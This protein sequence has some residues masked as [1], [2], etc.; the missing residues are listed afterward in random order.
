MFNLC[1]YHWRYCLA[2][3]QFTV[4]VLLL[5]LLIVIL[6]VVS[7]H[8][9]QTVM[10]S[11]G[12]SVIWMAVLLALFISLPA[13]FLED[14]QD[15]SLLQW[16]LQPTPLPLVFAIRMAVFWSVFIL[17]MVIL[18]PFVAYAFH[19]T[20]PVIGIFTLSLFLGS[21]ALYGI[22]AIIAALL[23]TSQH[24]MALL[25]V[26]LLPFFIPVMILGNSVVDLAQHGQ[27]VTGLI[28]LILAYTLFILTVSPFL[29]AS[30]VRLVVRY[31]Y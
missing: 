14:Y 29:V 12:H 26:L 28:G 25:S 19:M 21:L 23:L 13:L 5:F 2:Q 10:R 4:Q 3:R 17:P 30:I 6:F 11:L 24:N 8:F 1:R 15:G 27:S 16:I 9:D 7:N 22:G 31:D 18:A 20:A